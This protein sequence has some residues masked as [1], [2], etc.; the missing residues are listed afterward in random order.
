MFRFLFLLSSILYLNTTS[1][2]QKNIFPFDDTGNILY[3]KVVDTPENNTEE[4]TKKAKEF[5]KAWYELKDKKFEKLISK[6]Y[7]YL[8][9]NEEEKV[10]E[11][12]QEYVIYPGRF[13]KHAKGAVSYKLVVELKDNKYRYYINNFVFHPYELNRYGK[14]APASGKSVALNMITLKDELL[15]E[16]DCLQLEEALQKNIT[17]LEDYMSKSFIVADTTEKKSSQISTDW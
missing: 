14:Y 10:F 2:G 16:S 3:Y 7:S 4:L 17:M 5:F 6:K 9:F 13:L 8:T 11:S 12:K 15:Q 1:T